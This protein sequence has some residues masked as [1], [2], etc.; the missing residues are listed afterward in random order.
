MDPIGAIGLAASLVSIVDFANKVVKKTY[1]VCKSASGATT[2]NIHID[3][4]VSD[5]QKLT[6][7]VGRETMGNSVHE[8]ALKELSVKCENVATEV[9]QLLNK[10]KIDGQHS[11][12]KSFKVS[13]N[14]MRKSREI[15][16]LQKRLG[17]YR[18]EILIRLT[19]VLK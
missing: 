17:Q 3:T 4:M 19:L 11:A 5:L 10:L 12:W 16:E 1:E 9:I 13:I 18:S 6:E 2:E 8:I 7:G 14:S 15:D